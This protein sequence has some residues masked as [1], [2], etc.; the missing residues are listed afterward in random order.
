MSEVTSN[1][2]KTTASHSVTDYTAAGVEGTSVQL[3]RI[4]G[5]VNLIAY[6]MTEVRSRVDSHEAQLAALTSTTQSLKE[7]A[8]ASKET[9]VA[10]ALALKDAKDQA[11]ATARQEVAKE[12]ARNALVDR[13]WLT[14]TRMLGFFGGFLAFASLLVT[15]YVA[16]R[17]TGP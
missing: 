12:Q 16:T 11:E 17:P 9:A 1:T 13:V 5:T 8:M 3:T 15:L 2:V 7:G 4:E 6:Q 14:P 10:L